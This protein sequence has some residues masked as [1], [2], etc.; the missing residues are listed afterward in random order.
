LHVSDELLQES[1]LHFLRNSVLGSKLLSQLVGVRVRGH[2][3][4]V[5]F[6]ANIDGDANRVLLLKLIVFSRLLLH[7]LLRGSLLL[8]LLS[9]LLQVDIVVFLAGG[10]LVDLLGFI[11]NFIFL[12]VQDTL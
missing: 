8:Y 7:L 4:A 5:R 9:L 6:V 10:R 3:D 1:T 12:F 11:F 2:H